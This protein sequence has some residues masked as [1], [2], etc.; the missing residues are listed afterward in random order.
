MKPGWCIREG[1]I[2]HKHGGVKRDWE[3]KS[4]FTSKG[5]DCGAQFESSEREK[6]RFA[7]KEKQSWDF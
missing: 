2:V 3:R 1:E 7:Q 5:E 6:N 4:V